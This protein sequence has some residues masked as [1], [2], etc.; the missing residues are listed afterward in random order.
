MGHNNVKIKE[1]LNNEE[2]SFA[3]ASSFIN[4]LYCLLLQRE[5]YAE[6]HRLYYTD[7]WAGMVRTFEQSLLEF[8]KALEECRILCDGPLKYQ[9]NLEFPQVRETCIMQLFGVI[10]EKN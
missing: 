2:I 8:Y 1:S 6:G 5:S 10:Y 7:D 3:S 9:D 4:S